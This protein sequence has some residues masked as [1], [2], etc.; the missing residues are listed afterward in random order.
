M[1]T[2]RVIFEQARTHHLGLEA[3]NFENPIFTF[4][5]FSLTAVYYSCKI[6]RPLEVA[7]FLF[8]FMY[9]FTYT[10][11]VFLFRHLPTEIAIFINVC[12]QIKCFSGDSS[13][14]F[15]GRFCSYP[16]YFFDYI[17][18]SNKVFKD[19][20]IFWTLHSGTKVRIWI[21]SDDDAVFNFSCIASWKPDQLINFLFHNSFIIRIRL[22]IFQTVNSYFACFRNITL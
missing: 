8:L 22:W 7:K 1:Q 12:Y 20:E 2:E 5:Y 13:S 6:Q 19:I 21:C 14:F 17:W 4:G 3:Q 9:S 11:I 15:R 18:S 16:T 10:N